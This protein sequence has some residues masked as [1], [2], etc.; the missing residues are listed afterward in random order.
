MRDGN[1]V[2]RFENDIAVCLRDGVCLRREGS[3]E[4]VFKKRLRNGRLVA[5]EMPERI[6]KQIQQAHGV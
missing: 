6:R 2:P 1:A 4:W 3:G 5:A